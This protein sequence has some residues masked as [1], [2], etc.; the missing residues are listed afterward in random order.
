MIP[1]RDFNTICTELVAQIDELD[2]HHL[3]AQDN[4]AVKKLK[5]EKGI[6]LVAVIP[7]ADGYGTATA[8]GD[9]HTSFFFVVTKPGNDNTPADELA[10]YEQTQLIV[11]QVKTKILER[12]EDGCSV[13]FRLVPSSFSIDPE[14]NIFGG[15]LGWSLSLTF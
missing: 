12:Q 10:A 13:F 8:N 3:V 9:N 6:I 11:E 7:S 15:F 1:I 14:F 2:H 5:D 4:Q